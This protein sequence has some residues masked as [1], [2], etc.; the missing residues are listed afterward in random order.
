M[1]EKMK[2]TSRLSVW[3][4]SFYSWRDGWSGGERREAEVERYKT[5]NE[6]G[7]LEMMAGE[8]KARSAPFRL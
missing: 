4:G 1:S 5:T 6:R 2:R 8:E 7:G 3:D